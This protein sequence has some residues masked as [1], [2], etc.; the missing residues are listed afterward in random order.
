MGARRA[1]ILGLFLTEAVVL[2]A[3]GGMLGI[4]VVVVLIDIVTLIAPNAPL[5]TAWPYMVA[6]LAL[7]VLIGL[8]AGIMPALRA[9]RMDPQ[10]AL[11]AE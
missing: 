7:S 2:G 4:T 3:I 6:A 5:R 1:N 10:E 9:A 8:A 11:R